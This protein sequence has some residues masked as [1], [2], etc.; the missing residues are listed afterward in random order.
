MPP[1]VSA[2]VAT[3]LPRGE[4]PNI[5]TNPIALGTYV[6]F[7]C[8]RLALSAKAA[9]LTTTAARGGGSTGRTNGASSKDR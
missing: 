8:T 3:C 1:A 4:L 2:E 5:S 6:F 7:A 9:R